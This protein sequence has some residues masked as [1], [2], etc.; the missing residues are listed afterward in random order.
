M[1]NTIKYYK[2]NPDG[3]FQFM[4]TKNEDT[5]TPLMIASSVFDT[6]HVIFLLDKFAIKK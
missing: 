4:I 5:M 1:N 6:K 3:L 2:G